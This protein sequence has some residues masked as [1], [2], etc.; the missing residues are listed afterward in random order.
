MERERAFLNHRDVV[1]P[2]LKDAFKEGAH[3]IKPKKT[4]RDQWFRQIMIGVVYNDIGST[5]TEEELADKYGTFRQSISDSNKFFLGNLWNNSSPTLQDRY[6]LNEVLTARKPWGQPSRERFSAVRGGA[7][8][9]IKEQV[10]SEVT[11]PDKISENTGIS[12]QKIRQAATRTLKSWGIDVPRENA[13]YIEILEQLDKETDD[14]KIQELLD[15]L[16]YYVIPHD[17]AKEKEA[18]RFSSLSPLIR[19][20]GFRSK[21]NLPFATSLKADGVGAPIAIKD[22]VVKGAKPRTLTYYF[23]L[24]RHKDRAIKALKEDQSLQKFQR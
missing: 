2:F 5:A 1:Q 15:G 7:S 9:R 22:R 18:S 11:D 19:E 14:K 10:E 4:K 16:P 12:K 3:R 17:M 24:S 8:L 13:S 20:A 23:L 6:P 21:Y